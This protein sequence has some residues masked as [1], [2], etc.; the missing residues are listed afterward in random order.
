[1]HSFPLLHLDI[2]ELL[3]SN[4]QNLARRHHQGHQ[5]SSS[6][7]PQRLVYYALTTETN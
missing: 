6:A 3:H 4:G 1:M 5:T 7:G 2:E